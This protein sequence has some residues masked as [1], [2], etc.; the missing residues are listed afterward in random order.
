MKE[1]K[2]ILRQ[3]RNDNIGVS[4]VVGVALML[5]IMV[6]LV[7]STMIVFSTMM[8]QQRQ[9]M[10]EQVNQMMAFSEYLR[11]LK[12]GPGTGS[13]NDSTSPPFIQYE[14]NETTGQWDFYMCQGHSYQWVQLIPGDGQLPGNQTSQYTLTVIVVGQGSVTK[15]PQQTSYFS[16]TSV[17]LNATGDTGWVFMDWSGDLT[18][19]TNPTTITMN[20][21]KTVYATFRNIF[22]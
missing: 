15:N 22:D 20:D 4:E 17:E 12:F 19:T 3:M 18:G 2:K 13:G 10:D 6:P 21:N 8:D 7:S 9:M 5:A 16:G 1:I 14:F 11:G